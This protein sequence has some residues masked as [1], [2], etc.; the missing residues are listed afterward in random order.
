M[1]RYICVDVGGTF[2]DAAVL[3][4]NGKI[5]IFKSLTTY[6]DYIEGIT[7]SLKVAAD[8]YAEPFDQFLWSCSPENGGA[9]THGS[10]IATNAVVQHK[11]GKVGMICTKGFRDVLLF[12]E[13]PIKDPFE[14]QINYPEPYIPR[15]LT[16]PVSERINSEGGVDASLDEDEVKQAVKQLREWNVEAIAVCFMWSVVNPINEQ[17]TKEIIHEEW[18]EVT[19]VLSSEVNPCIREYRRWVSAVMD[20]SL[21]RLVSTY[22]AELDNR[23]NSL[24][25]QGGVGMLNSTGGV[26]STAEIVARP[27][28]TL[29]SGPA[30][31]PVAG[32]TYVNDDLGENNA[33]V[34]DMGGTTFDVSCVLNG[35]IPESREAKVGHEIPGISRVDVHSIGAGGGSIAWVDAGGM[36]RVGPL[37]AGSTPGPACYGR[38]GT[39]PTVTDANVVLGYLNPDYFN[40][41]RMGLDAVLAEKVIREHVADPLGIDVREAA[42]T[43]WSTVNANMVAAIKD[44]TIWQGIDPR[45]YVMVVGGGACG[46]HATPLAEGLEMKKVLI[47]RTAGGLSAV[48]GIYSKVVSEYS[49]S[50]YAETRKF[51]FVGVNQVLRSLQDEATA[52]FERNNIPEDKR[53]IEIYMEGRYPYQVW[54]IPLRIDGLLNKDGE[55]DEEAV[56]KMVESFHDEHEKIFAVKESSAY[57]ECIYWRLEALGKREMETTIK[58]ADTKSEEKLCKAA[59]KG[60]RKAYFKELSGMVDTPV[61]DGEELRYGNI[62]LGPA[63]IEE[64]TTTVVI[65]PNHEVQVTK[66]NNYFIK[67]I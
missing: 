6:P 9:L 19:V 53:I 66:Y 41:G 23:L 43:I 40:A 56:S 8:Y 62:I 5:N 14:F 20:A 57:L 47:P 61:Y 37:S 10:T 13:G 33:V 25:F 7:D 67:R 39:R 63:I 32:K 38:G 58:E 29:D 28:Y 54:E 30:L 2:T 17:R 59:L 18:P 65:N 16:L 46:V 45:D 3:D 60:T 1:A 64:P 36:V 12:R 4:E 34:L 31:A 42:F 52:F 15:Y 51:D 22:A 44:I 21:R 24:G 11:V 26:V 55:F 48:G 27:L 35:S 49:R 50:Y